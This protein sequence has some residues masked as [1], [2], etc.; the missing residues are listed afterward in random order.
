MRGRCGRNRGAAA[1]LLNLRERAGVGGRHALAL[2]GRPASP[3]VRIVIHASP[4]LTGSTK[5]PA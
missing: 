5:P 2:A 1:G 4:P 3:P